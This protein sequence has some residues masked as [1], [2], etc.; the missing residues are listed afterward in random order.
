M[1][2]GVAGDRD[3]QDAATIQR[4]DEPGDELG[5]AGSERAVANAG[6]IGDPCIGVRSEGAAAFVVDEVV[7]QTNET[8]GVVEREQLETAH[9]EHRSGAGQTQHLG[10]RA[11]TGHRAGR[12]DFA[13]EGSWFPPYGARAQRSPATNSRAL[14][15]SRRPNEAARVLTRL[16]MPSS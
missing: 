7:V 13:L 16:M 11:P 14:M 8:D 10:K 3:D 5:R 6:A 12:T 15:P 4:L 1:P 2:I 9:A